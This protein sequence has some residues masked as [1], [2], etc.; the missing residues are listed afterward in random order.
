LARH[1]GR[2]VKLTGD[3]ALAEF[4]S[5]VD[6]LGAAIEF[7]QLMAEAN[8]DQPEDTRIVFRVGLHLGDLIVDGDDL[9][10]VGV[11][12]AA[13]LEGEAPPGGILI[14]GNVYDAVV[15]RLKATFDDLGSLALKNIERPTQ[16]FRVG[17]LP[18]DWKVLSVT[19]AQP[20]L[21]ASRPGTG[22]ALALPDKPSIAVLPFQNMSADPE[23]EYF[24]DGMVEEIITALSRFKSLFVIARNSSFTYKGKAVDIRT[25]GRELG[26][27]YVLEGSVR[28]AGNRVRITGQ[29][30][31]SATGT[32]LWADRFESSLEDIFELQDQMATS[33]VGAVAPKL[34][35]VEIERAKLKPVENLDAYDCLLRGMAHSYVQTKEDQE[36]ARRLFYRAIELDPNYPAPYALAARYY[37]FRPAYDHKDWEKAEIRRLALR[38]SA[39]GREDA[40]ALCWAGISLFRVCGEYQTG[41]A[42]MDQALS[43]N[44]NLAV[45]WRMRGWAS[46][47]LGEHESAL[48]QF[49]RALRLSPLDPESFHSET[50]MAF[51]HLFQ[52]RYNEAM[53]W[54]G[55]ALARQ[56]WMPTMRALAAA[57]ALA[58]NIDEA[59]NIMLRMRELEPA[60]CISRL[61]EFLPYRRSEDVERMIEGLRLAGLPE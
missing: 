40:L 60:M 41:M 48:K 47:Y 3:G 54:A 52:G 42:M 12:V 37:A 49:G 35:Q 31:D 13:R 5:A 28:R 50:A 25:V 30:I 45:G 32:H 43:L 9:Y 44:Q 20:S 22:N 6:A 58:G 27:R 8:R 7:Q 26:V 53:T 18:A 4:P 14:S 36:E 57:N 11:N 61:K 19:A 2:L 10:G 15:G 51:A 34:D 38:V 21:D 59:R 16:A 56:H 23:Q 33:V 39:I 17:W 1:G 55:S 46:L 24:A 29:L